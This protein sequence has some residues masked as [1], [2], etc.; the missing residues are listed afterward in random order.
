[1]II[2][3]R[4][5]N[6]NDFTLNAEFLN[7]QIWH[8]DESHVS[9]YGKRVKIGPQRIIADGSIKSQT[10]FLYVNQSGVLTESTDIPHYFENRKGWYRRTTIERCI[11]QFYKNSAGGFDAQTPNTYQRYNPTALRPHSYSLNVNANGTLKDITDTSAGIT[12]TKGGPL[13]DTQ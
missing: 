2:H 12:V 10:S 5:S 11:S 13:V 6:E 8:L 4:F 3:K 1:M 7:N 9:V